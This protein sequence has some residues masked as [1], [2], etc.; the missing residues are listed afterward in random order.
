MFLTFESQIFPSR[1]FLQARHALIFFVIINFHILGFRG[2][3][4]G[5]FRSLGRI[6]QRNENPDIRQIKRQS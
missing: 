4:A 6:L 2:L 3:V 1:I 5:V